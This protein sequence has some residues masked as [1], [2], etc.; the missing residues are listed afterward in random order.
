MKHRI[1][2]LC[3]AFVLGAFMTA[4]P[5]CAGVDDE[6]ARHETALETS[7]FKYTSGGRGITLATELTNANFMVTSV[8]RDTQGHV[9]AIGVTT[10]NMRTNAAGALGCGGRSR[11]EYTTSLENA[12]DGCGLDDLQIGDLLYADVVGTADTLPILYEVEHVQWLGHGTDI[13]GDEFQSVIRHEQIP[14]PDWAKLYQEE[15]TFDTVPVITGDV[16]EDD[17]VSITDVISVNKYLLG[18][19]A[20]LPCQR[21][22]AD[23]DGSGEINAVDS[24]N[25]LKFVV[26]MIPDFDEL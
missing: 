8:C 15:V 21:L 20:Y 24:L 3:S 14:E 4:M 19:S 16:D 1:I 9:K 13:L 22:S 18:A 26:E 23:V 12:L 2:A 25:I 17:T 11:F 5:V 6:F 10:I 7:A